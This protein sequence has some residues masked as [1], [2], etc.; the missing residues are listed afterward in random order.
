MSLGLRV[1][2]LTVVFS[3]AT[4]SSGHANRTHRGADPDLLGP[5][6]TRTAAVTRASATAR[7]STSTSGITGGI[8]QIALSM[9]APPAPDDEDD[10]QHPPRPVMRLNIR[11]AVLEPE[12]FDNW[13]FFDG[14]PEQG[15]RRRLEDVLDAKIEATG[16][17]GELTE[18][19]RAKLRLAGR[20]DIK[21]FFDRVEDRRREFE[22][23]RQ[24]WQTG[25]A[26]LQRLGDLSIIYQEGPFG[27][28]SLFAKTLRR[29]DDDRKAGH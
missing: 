26:A 28:G 14:R 19:Q 4:E 13:L 23:A 7:S 29:I 21:R 22:T 2:K 6:Q 27:D 10:D 25:F 11:Q 8:R 5:G 1:A 17:M 20:G 16:R 12:N 24:H 3:T 15:R 9:P 18:R